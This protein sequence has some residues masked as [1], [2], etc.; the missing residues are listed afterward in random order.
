MGDRVHQTTDR[1][2]LY[3]GGTRSKQTSEHS[4]G[5]FVRGGGCVVGRGADSRTAPN[6][7]ERQRNDCLVVRITA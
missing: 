5:S 4:G 2:V 7:S 6:V 1:L 3:F